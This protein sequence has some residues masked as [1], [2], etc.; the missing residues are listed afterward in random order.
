MSAP[1]QNASD[2]PLSQNTGTLPQ[3]GDALLSWFQAM[4]FT[5][6]VK[7]VVNSLVVE[8]PTNVSFQGVWQP[9]TDQAL[10]MK[11][12]GQRKWKWFML[13]ADT[14]LSLEPDDVVTYQGTQFRVMAKKDYSPYAYIEYHLAQ[15]YTGSGPG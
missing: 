4:V 11:P 6:I 1:I 8:T 5:T 13:H 2:I 10:L 12:I 15:D 7:T 14:T 9:F 3:M